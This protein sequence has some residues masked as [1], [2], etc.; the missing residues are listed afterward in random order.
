ML[1]HNKSLHQR[2]LSGGIWAFSAKAGTGFLTIALTALITRLLAPE[3]VGVLFLSFSI[4]IMVSIISRFGLG[5]LG[6]KLIGEAFSDNNYR[7]A[8]NITLKNIT[9][10]TIFSL[11]F[12]FLSFIAFSDI[13]SIFFSEREISI[14]YQLFFSLWILV[15]S[16]QL[17][18]A[19]VFRSY[20]QIS[21]A[22]IFS[23]GT[24]FGGFF[25]SLFVGSILLLFFFT[26]IDLTLELVL[27]VILIVTTV[28][29]VI[30][31]YLIFLIF[32]K[33]S[34]IENSD[35]DNEISI[36][37]LEL[38]KQ[39]LPFIVTIFSSYALI[40]LDVVILGFFRPDEEVAVYAAST[41]TVKLILLTSIVAYE[42]VA[43]VIV[44]LHT[45]NQIEKL[46]NMLRIAATLAA[47]PAAVVLLVF[48]FSAETVL[49][50]L[51]GDYY[52]EGADILVVLSIAQFINL[53][54][55]LCGYTMSMMG[56]QKIKMYI[57]S[58]VTFIALV[59]CVIFA[60]E[61]GG[62][63]VAYIIG[64]AWILQNLLVLFFTKYLA[65]IWTH[66]D[67]ISSYKAVASFVRKSGIKY[68]GDK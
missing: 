24:V 65:G 39:G 50:F 6:I 57:F 19:E 8:Q 21:Q 58:S 27:S 20:H 47:I 33:Y 37:Y 22:S 34:N 4:V 43:P 45:E 29:L 1:H 66:V 35:N 60:N 36:G 18:F 67:I 10:I 59:S 5:Q 68:Q 51:Y 40:H 48:I 14:T 54:T 26:G 56:Y 2:L 11:I 28:S 3:D 7:L 25:V 31:G 42:V 46:E 44:E 12:S 15:T 32:S 41:R 62:I 30:E 55:G 9:L 13:Y 49:G 52:I 38:I 53:W 63:A 16:L 64:L 61:Y 17:Y 23:G